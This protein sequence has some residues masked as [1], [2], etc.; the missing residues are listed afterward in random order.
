LTPDQRREKF[1]E[2]LRYGGIDE[3]IAHQR[4]AQ[5][6]GMEALTGVRTLFPF[7]A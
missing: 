3:R 4:L 7:S 1:L 2:C 5:L 6:E